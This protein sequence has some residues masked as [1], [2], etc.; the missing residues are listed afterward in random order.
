MMQDVATALAFME[1]KK[2]IHRDIK[3]ANIMMDG[4]G[5]CKLTDFG[6]ARVLQQGGSQ[7]IA[8]GT[9]YYMAPEVYSGHHYDHRA[10]IY[11]LGIVA[12]YFLNSC[13][14]PLVDRGYRPREAWNERMRG[15][16]CPPL[17]NVSAQINRVLLKCIAYRPENR[18]SSAADLLRDLDKLRGQGNIPIAGGRAGRDD[19]GPHRGGRSDPEDDRRYRGR[20]YDRDSDRRQNGYNSDPTRGGNSGGQGEV[21]QQGGE[22]KR[23]STGALVGIILGSVF[24]GL[25]LITLIIVAAANGL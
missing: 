7:T 12:Y 11:S 22:K 13:Q 1:G 6:E 14:Y 24:G 16:D 2:I 18:Y 17:N 9:P 19:P 15:A 20:S 25:L 21:I 5:H 8:R 10:D 3:P 23:L 4:R